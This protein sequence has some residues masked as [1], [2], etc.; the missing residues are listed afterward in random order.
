MT[1]VTID[2]RHKRH[3][4]RTVLEHLHIGLAGGQF[5]CL[6]GPS[7]CG[8]TTLLNL[9]AGLD[10]QFEGDIRLARSGL[11]PRIGYMFQEP[12]LLP[13]R[14]VAENL[15]LAL[16]ATTD[17][18]LVETLMSRVGLV[19]VQHQYPGQLSLGMRRRVALVRAFAV[20]PDLLL[21]DEPL[22][23]LDAPTARKIRE[24]LLQLWQERP[25]TVLYVTHDL[26][27][28][29]ELADRLIFLSPPPCRIVRD[30]LV[31]LARTERNPARIEA[32]H[33]SLRQD[34]PELA[35]LL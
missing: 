31:P 30:S 15:H 26:R 33:Q 24:L 14:T 16:P 11:P 32:L 12:R 5:T 23:S 21:M 22:V 35:G 27:E 25:H 1:A 29:V 2:I 19:D 3:G 8:K 7:G 34:F 10:H 17:P 13:W 20:V 18:E 9:V 6:V 28:A 4:K